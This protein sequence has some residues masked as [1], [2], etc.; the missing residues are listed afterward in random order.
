VF[1][2]PYKLLDKQAKIIYKGIDVL[3][4]NN[5]KYHVIQVTYPKDTEGDLWH[6]YIDINSFKLSATEI[7][8][9]NKISFINNEL[10]E[11]KTGLSLNKT[12][13]SYYLNNKREIKYL[14]ADYLYSI[15]SFKKN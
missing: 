12:R 1:W 3:S 9:N 15:I 13:K 7:N 11:T 6:Y 8:H 4:F 14:R 2:Q 10:V 5:K